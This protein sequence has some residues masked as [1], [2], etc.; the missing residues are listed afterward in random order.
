MCVYFFL[1]AFFLP[2]AFLVL[3]GWLMRACSQAWLKEWI[4]SSMVVLQRLLPPS[5]FCK[6]WQI[7]FFFQILFV[8]GAWKLI[9]FSIS[10]VLES[11][12]YIFA[13][14]VCASICIIVKSIINI[15]DSQRIP[16]VQSYDYLTSWTY[17]FDVLMIISYIAQPQM[18]MAQPQMVMQ[19]IAVAQPVMMA[20]PIMQQPV[21]VQ[22][23]IVTA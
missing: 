4:C 14:Y 12:I 8:S 9:S 1:F 21:G 7:Q 3:D 13:H 18:V 10:R 19:P 6:E 23:V 11:Y 5:K 20:Q 17:F 15:L 16:N 2:Q 22:S